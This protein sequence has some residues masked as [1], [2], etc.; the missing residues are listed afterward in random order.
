MKYSSHSPH[1]VFFTV[2]Y[3]VL[4]LTEIS[5][6]YEKFGFS[7]CGKWS[8][9]RLG[10]VRGSLRSR[11]VACRR[12]N[13]DWI[14]SYFSAIAFKESGQCAQSLFATEGFYFSLS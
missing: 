14:L 2:N 12:N 7:L 1:A 4:K 13:D 6:N 5:C 3:S 9:V 8:I 11:I 10:D